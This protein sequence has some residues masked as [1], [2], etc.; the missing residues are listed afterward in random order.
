MERYQ[1]NLT[2]VTYYLVNNAMPPGD[3]DETT[4]LR[5]MQAASEDALMLEM[6]GRVAVMIPAEVVEMLGNDMVK[7]WHEGENLC[8]GTL[9]ALKELLATVGTIAGRK[10]W[11]ARVQHFI[12]LPAEE[13]ERRP[14]PAQEP[15]ENVIPFRDNAGKKTTVLN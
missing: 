6:A 15:A 13:V 12:D 2:L 9:S 10:E 3:I 7:H 4:L 5:L 1:P 11:N 8:P 14:A